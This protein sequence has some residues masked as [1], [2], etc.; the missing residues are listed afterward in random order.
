MVVVTYDT[1][2]MTQQVA[3]VETPNATKFIAVNDE[4]G[5]IMIFSIGSDGVF[6]LTKETSVGSRNI[7]NLS[8]ALNIV[9]AKISAF[10]V[11]QNVKDTTLYIVVAS[12][13]GLI[14]LKP[15]KPRDV[16]LEDDHLNLTP[17]IM[18]GGPRITTAQGIFMVSPE[19][20]KSIENG[21]EH[22]GADL[23]CLFRTKALSAT[24]IR[25]W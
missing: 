8:R 24:R 10:D 23:Y 14:V 4:N 1:E 19:E 6:Y 17:F 12:T 21:I 20:K 18:G 13:S 5:S 3:A 9:G 15:F 25:T 16:L 11:A 7:V 2:L 22:D